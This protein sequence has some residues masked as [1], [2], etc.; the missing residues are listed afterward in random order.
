MSPSRFHVLPVREIS[1]S[2]VTTPATI[3]CLRFASSRQLFCSPFSSRISQCRSSLAFELSS[4]IESGRGTPDIGLPDGVRGRS[5]GPEGG[6]AAST[7]GT[8][9]LVFERL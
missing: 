9:T 1:D 5:F 3:H 8:P 7:L 2:R 6:V 4:S